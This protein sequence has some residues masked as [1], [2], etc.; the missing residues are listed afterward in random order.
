MEIILE[1]K[2][3]ELKNPFDILIE[4]VERKIP[5]DL[6]RQL[7]NK[8][9]RRNMLQKCGNKAF[10]L[11]D[12][13]KFPIM[14]PRTCKLDCRLLYAAFLR[15]NQYKGKKPGY[16]ELVL[17]IKELFQNNGCSRQIG[18][19]LEGSDEIIALDHFIEFLE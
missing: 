7:S 4:E 19:H 11:P 14:D 12:Q 13:L 10:L 2:I 17:K 8:V 16:S 3:E 6:K 15:A 5:E 9:V 1:H 18:I